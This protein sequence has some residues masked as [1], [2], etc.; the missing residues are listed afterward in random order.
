V[1]EGA[2]KKI[3]RDRAKLNNFYDFKIDNKKL[4]T[5][6]DRTWKSQK[7]VFL[8]GI[9]FGFFTEYLLGNT[10]IYENIVRKATMRRLSKCLV[11]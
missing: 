7:R 4:D 10:R 8:I 5:I 6:K 2:E 9:A 11:M 1:V 3:S